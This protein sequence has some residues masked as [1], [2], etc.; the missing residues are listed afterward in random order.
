[1]SH[2]LRT[3]TTLFLGGIPPEYRRRGYRHV[4][5][6]MFYG[7]FFAVVMNL[8][9]FVVRKL[10]GTAFQSLLVNIAQGL[11]L[12]FAVLWVPLTE[13]RNPVRLAGLLLASG[14]AL[15]MFC[16][17][18]GGLW[19]FVVILAAARLLST[20]ANPAL[21]TAL[22]QIYPDRWRGKLLSLPYTANMLVRMGCVAA[23]GWMLQR[24]LQ[25]YRWIFPAAGLA[26]LGGGVLFRGI[27]GGRGDH[28][29]ASQLQ[30]GR[31]NRLLSPLRSAL[32]N[33][34]LLIFLIGYFVASC[35]GVSYFNALPLFASDDLGLTPQQWS[36]ARAGFMVATLVSFF[37]WGVFMDRFGAPL[38]AVVSWV[39]Q[40]AIILGMSFVTSWPM[41]FALVASRGLFQSGNMMAFF[42]VVMYFSK[43]EETSRAMSLHFSL[44]GIRWVL[45]PLLV[46]AVID[47][48][49][50]PI[51][52][53]FLVSAAFAAAGTVVMAA[54]WWRGARTPVSG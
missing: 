46:V 24:D 1:M 47:G 36:L 6:W 19:S 39:G 18:G 5:S 45:A 4:A 33:R 30:E 52:H 27:R 21:G 17:L 16:G 32:S 20:L 34:P 23:A 53:L 10:G 25:L 29:P 13:R 43:P 51:R 7:V 31:L 11:P 15:L 14:G 3:P 22:R 44:W 8:G 2:D 54:V 28:R 9:P 50:F 38:T 35:G 41:L 48:G 42:P 37:V 40:C 12:V 49:L 26:A